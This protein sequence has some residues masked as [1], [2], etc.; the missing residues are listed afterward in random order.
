[1]EG[2]SVELSLLLLLLVDVEEEEDGD[3]LSVKEVAFIDADIEL[4]EFASLLFVG[5]ANDGNG[6]DGDSGASGALSMH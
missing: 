5:V 3:L 4:I 1:V 6:D 2:K